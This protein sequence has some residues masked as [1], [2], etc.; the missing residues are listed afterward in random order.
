MYNEQRMLN[1]LMIPPRLSSLQS[2]HRAQSCLNTQES[3][4]PIL[5]L[6]CELMEISRASIHEG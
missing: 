3:Q 4:L 5:D 1:S 6:D 2:C